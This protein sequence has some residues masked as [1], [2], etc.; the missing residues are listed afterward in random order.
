MPSS[1]RLNPS[2]TPENNLPTY[3]ELRV[4]ELIFNDPIVITPFPADAQTGLRALLRKI[5]NIYVPCT[6]NTYV[7]M[8]GP[9]FF[10]WVEL[11][12]IAPLYHTPTVTAVYDIFHQNIR[13]MS[14]PALRILGV[15]GDAPPAMD[16]EHAMAAVMATGTHVRSPS[17]RR[18]RLL[19]I[20][21]QI[22]ASNRSQNLNGLPPRDQP[23]HPTNGSN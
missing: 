13:I 4:L 8:T 18:R 7:A 3:D 6:E 1:S 16:N 15:G 14:L 20:L 10:G 11:G 5:G 12:R 9:L 17:P 22:E 2:Q 21:V 23:S 19:E